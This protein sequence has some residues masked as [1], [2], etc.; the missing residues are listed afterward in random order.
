M[1]QDRED[2]VYLLKGEADKQCQKVEE[3]LKILE[4]NEVPRTKQCLQDF[5]DKNSGANPTVLRDE[6]QKVINPSCTGKA[7][8]AWK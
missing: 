2:I 5:F 6:M 7:Q 1:L 8:R 3:L 4:E